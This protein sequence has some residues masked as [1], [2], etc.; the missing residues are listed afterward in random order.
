MLP[1][2]PAPKGPP[3]Q[4]IHQRLSSFRQWFRGRA[5]F[6]DHW[7]R[8]L[9]FA[10]SALLIDSVERSIVNQAGYQPEHLTKREYFEIFRKYRIC[11]QDLINHRLTWNLAIQ[12]LLF[13]TY[14]LCLQKL[15]ELESGE[16]GAH[17]EGAADVC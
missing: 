8:G 15:A 5:L 14:G 3:K 13:A 16:N 1:P 2:T 12:G 10:D 4:S 7:T 9:G 11:E 17:I 6:I